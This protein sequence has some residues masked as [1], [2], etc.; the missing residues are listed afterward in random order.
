MEPPASVASKSVDQPATTLQMQLKKI[1]EDTL[2]RKPIGIRENFFELGGH[3]LLAARLMQKVSRLVD[4]TVPLALLF[5][6][7]TIEKLAEV[8]DRNEWGQQWSCLVPIQ[9][10]GTR[11]PIFCVHGVGGNV[12]GFRELAR[13]MTP[14]YPF[15]GFQAQGLDGSRAPFTNIEEM[16]AHYIREMRGVQ[17]EGPFFLGGYSFGGLV[18]YEMARQLY[19]GGEEVA[20]LALLDTYPGELEAVTTSIWKLL[21]E[22]KRLRALSDVPKT[23]KKSVQRRVKRLFLSKTLKDVLQANHGASARYELQPYE[24]KTTLFRAEQS[25]L[26]AFDDPHAAWASLAVGGL[27]IEEISGDHGDILMMPQ[28]GE[29]AKK[30]KVAIDNAVAERT[31]S[32]TREEEA[33]A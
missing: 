27:Q 20:L 17:P 10:E 15:Y 29:L 12:V 28:V 1:W 31:A 21:L 22:P 4:K 5:D 14:D 8:L 19:A 2:G 11:P 25:S 18:A 32:E 24:G 9:P 16:A 7:P 23:A 26:R 33:L 3:S 30:L 13:L 6:A